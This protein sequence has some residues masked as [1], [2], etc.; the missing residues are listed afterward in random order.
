MKLSVAPESTRTCLLA[1]ECELC[2]IVG[3]LIDRYL[4]VNTL[5]S[6]NRFAQA[7]GVTRVKDPLPY[8]L[9]HPVQLQPS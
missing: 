8:P 4:Q 7:D 1:F 5:F 3:I 2:M 6:C 9:P